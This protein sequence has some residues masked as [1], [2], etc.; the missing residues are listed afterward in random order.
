MTHFRFLSRLSKLLTQQ[1]YRVLHLERGQIFETVNR[2][3]PSDSLTEKNVIEDFQVSFNSPVMLTDDHVDNI[4]YQ[5]FLST[6]SIL[7]S[8]VSLFNLLLNA[9]KN[10]NLQFSKLQHMFYVNQHVLML[11]KK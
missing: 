4:L 1:L 8:S 9:L 6:I 2:T 10:C 11:A 7:L 3:S 5:I